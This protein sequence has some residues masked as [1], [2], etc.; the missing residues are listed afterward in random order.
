MSKMQNPKTKIKNKKEF[1]PVGRS[2]EDD[3]LHSWT[4]NYCHH[5]YYINNFYNK[6]TIPYTDIIHIAY[7]DAIY[8]LDLAL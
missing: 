3:S 7:I 5:I 6:D 8:P 4:K 2:R 1:Q